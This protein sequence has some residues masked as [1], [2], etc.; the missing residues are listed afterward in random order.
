LFI[1]KTYDTETLKDTERAVLVGV[2]MPGRFDYEFQE[3]LE[4]LKLLAVSAG[5]EVSRTV[6][7]ERKKID[8][9]FFI[10]KGKV[11]EIRQKLEEADAN[12]VIFDE[13]LSPAQVR[14]LEREL[15]AKVIDRTTLILDI[16][17]NRARTSEAK[18]QVELAQLNHLLPRLTRQWTHLSKQYGGIGTKGPGETQLETDRRMINNKIKMLKKKLEKIDNER[19]TQRKNRLDLFRVCLVGYTN[20]GKSTLFNCLTKS[21]VLIEDRLF[22]TLD[23]TTRKLSAKNGSNILLT[24]TVGFI[25]KLPH[26][27]VASFK[28]TLDEVR[29]ANLLLHVVDFGHPHY[30]KRILNV[31]EVLADIGADE[32]PTIIVFNKIDISPEPYAEFGHFFTADLKNFFISAKKRQGIEHLIKRIMYLAD[33]N[34]SAMGTGEKWP[35]S[36][37]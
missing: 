31:R 10:G 32:I 19:N 9:A 18:I 8:P 12:L 23:S 6:T 21:G 29:Y 7:Q 34:N 16:F 5:A 14:N 28:S 33:D 37:S 3:S 26:Q 25:N 17:V 27:L 36:R 30:M 22:S 24:D 4:E 15:N 20:A 11:S 35:N 13:E 2:K 1:A